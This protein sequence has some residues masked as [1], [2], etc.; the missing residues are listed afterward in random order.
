M[1]SL[2]RLA[3]A[4]GVAYG[5]TTLYKRAQ[6]RQPRRVPE[7]VGR[8]EDEG[9]AVPIHMNKTAAQVSPEPPQ[10]PRSAAE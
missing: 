4:A 6:A 10:D 1:T 5:L 3:A 7:E 9:G 8:W 2:L